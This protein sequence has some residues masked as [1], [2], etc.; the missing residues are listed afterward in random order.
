MNIKIHDEGYEVIVEKKRIKNTYIRV[1]EDLKIYVS[2]NILTSKK[3]IEDLIL[4]NEDSI[5]SSF[6]VI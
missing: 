1:K 5:Y 6:T 3:Y 2:T 4:K